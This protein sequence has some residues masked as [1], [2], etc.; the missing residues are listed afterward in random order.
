M[1]K[2]ALHNLGCKVNAYETEA[3]QE[4]LERSGYEIVPFHE[5]ADVYVIN[6][7]TVTN[8]AD[9][10]SRQM[11][12]RAR[13]MNPDA[14]V[15]AAGCYVQAKAG[16][17]DDCV[18]IVIGNNRKHELA[19]ILEEYWR[20]EGEKKEEMTDIIHAPAYEE[21]SPDPDRRAHPRLHQG[22]GRV[23]P[24][25]FLLHHSLRKGQGAQPAHGGC[26]L[27]SGGSGPAGIPGGGPHGD[28]SELLRD[29]PWRR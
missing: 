29:R 12:H 20:S 11:L 22:A 18:D 3:M 8:M 27:G 5:K 26:G 23:Q 24:V 2:A 15:V 25:L 10:K 4:I 7:C 28:P 9:R 6:T 14:V 16:E 1:K 13:K 21:M 17:V 19:G